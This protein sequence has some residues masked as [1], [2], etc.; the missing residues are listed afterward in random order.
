MPRPSALDLDD[1]SWASYLA[2]HRFDRDAQRE[3]ARPHRDLES[4]RELQRLRSGAIGFRTRVEVDT[5]TLP[6]AITDSI[7]T[8]LASHGVD[9]AAVLRSAGL[10]AERVIRELGRNTAQIVLLDEVES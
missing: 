5:G 2:D 6:G 4:E 10:D 7:R 3:P 8:T 9:L 1:A